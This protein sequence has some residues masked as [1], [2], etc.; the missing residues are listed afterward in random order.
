VRLDL[1]PLLRLLAPPACAACDVGLPDDGLLCASCDAE[2]TP[3]MAELADGPLLVAAG[4]Y[5]GGLA[6][7]IRRM[8]Y[9]ARPDLARPIG[10]RVAAALRAAKL[11]EPAC[12]VPVPLHPRRL[13][14]RGYNQSALVATR[15]AR[16][17]GWP[18]QCLGLARERDTAHQAALER[19]DR[20]VNVVDAFVA[21]VALT[22]Q[23]VV[24]VDDVVTTGATALACTAALRLCGARVVAIAAVARAP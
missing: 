5:E 24:L 22:G 13:A 6:E 9:G 21:H 11:E 2:P 18:V 19:R 10:T 23:R 12:L 17:L 14:E 20:L 1:A 4:P 7:A 15:M 3:Y 8:K 16:V